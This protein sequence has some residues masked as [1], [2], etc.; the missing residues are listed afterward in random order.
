MRREDAE[1][2]AIAAELDPVGEI[3][4]PAVAGVEKDDVGDVVAQAAAIQD[5]RDG[6][7]S[8]AV[9]GDGDSAD[10]R[11]R[12]P[13][14]VVR[15]NITNVMKFEFLNINLPAASVNEPLSHGFI[16]YRI[17]PK[18]GLADGT[19]IENKADIFVHNNCAIRSAAYN[20]HL[21]VIKY[22]IK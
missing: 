8:A 9:G 7:V 21:E 20:G 10:L 22:L 14:L 2:P 19:M 6:V 18:A 16:T 4:E 3:L 1:Q 5:R 15:R 13:F 17:H 11:C 12:K